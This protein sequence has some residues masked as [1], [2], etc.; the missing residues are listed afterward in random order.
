MSLQGAYCFN[1]P[2]ASGDTSKPIARR[3]A[4]LSDANDGVR[5]LFD[6]GFAWCY[7]GGPYS[8]RAAAGAPANGATIYDMVERANGSFVKAEA[9]TIG[10]SG[11]GFD[12]STMTA[13]TAGNNHACYVQADSAAWASIHASANDYFLWVAYVRLPSTADWNVPSG[14]LALFM[15][16]GVGETYVAQTDPL[17]VG[18]SSGDAMTFRRQTALNTVANL[19]VTPLAGH[20]GAV[21]QVAYWR[22]ASGTGARIKGAAGESS[23]SGAVGANSSLD[24]SAATPKWGV[25]P[26]WW[27]F[28]GASAQTTR[29]FRL[30]R[31]WLEDL[32]ASGRTPTTVLDADYARVV[33]RAAFT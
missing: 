1:S 7:P 2:A 5:F 6:T 15:S 3:D 4:L 10:F 12:F 21:C 19:S 18:F 17:T 16:A 9:Q 27:D 32:S 14:L 23:S 28:S 33:A 30:Y 26:S 22:N 11:N 13:N 25:P 24:F 31:G 20:Y 29:N 8:G